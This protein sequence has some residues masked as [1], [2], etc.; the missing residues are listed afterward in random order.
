M[1]EQKKDYDTGLKL[2]DASITHK[3][4]WFNVWTKAQ[5]LAAKGNYKDAYPLAQKAQTLGEKNPQGF[6][7]SDNIKAAL[8]DWKAKS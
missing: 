8:K 5:L 3:E 1:L 2:A 4:E 6:F 7:Y